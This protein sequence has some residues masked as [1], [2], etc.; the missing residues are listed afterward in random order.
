M[1]VPP[2]DQPAYPPRPSAYGEPAATTPV[3]PPVTPPAVQPVAQ[4]AVPASPPPA[5]QPVWAQPAEPVPPAFA[6]TPAPAPTSRVVLR[7]GPYW[8]GAVATGIVA[9]LVGVVGVLVFQSILDVGIVVKDP[10]GT[11]SDSWAYAVAGFVAAIAAAALLH[12]LLISTPRPRAFFGWI[13]AL[14]TVAAALLPLT[15]TDD[16]TAALCAGAVNLLVGIAIWSLLSGVL[17]RTTT[18]VTT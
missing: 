7:A 6:S 14:A 17:S 3:T 8:G 15:W 9:A 2:P 1:S 10:F 16:T 11:D 13:M 18:V 4:P 5:V 12:L